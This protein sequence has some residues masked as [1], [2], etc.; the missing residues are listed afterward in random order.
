MILKNENCIYI[1][2]YILL[3]LFKFV[4]YLTLMNQLLVYIKFIFGIESS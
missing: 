1:A 2:D 4:V 3:F